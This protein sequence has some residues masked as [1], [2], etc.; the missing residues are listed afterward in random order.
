MKVEIFT[1]KAP[2]P[3]GPYSQGLKVG[4]RIY[5]SGQRPVQA[6]TGNIP[7]SVREQ[8]EQVL[9]NVKSILEAGGASM[10]DVVKVT[11]YL[12]D[13]QYFAEFNKVY[14]EFFSS[15]YPV[16]T[17]VGC[18]LRGILVEVDVIAELS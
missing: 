1:E 15:P 14:E 10:K 3:A 16:R 4:N 5:V 12:A 2:R 6:E 17:T 11:A 9:L 7:H 18:E 8:T 13:V